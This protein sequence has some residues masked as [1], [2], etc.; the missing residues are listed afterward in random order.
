M[1]DTFTIQIF[2]MNLLQITMYLG[3]IIAIIIM[4]LLFIN[5]RR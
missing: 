5:T 2:G 4:L 1:S 3:I